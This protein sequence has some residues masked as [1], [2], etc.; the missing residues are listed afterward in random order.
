MWSGDDEPGSDTSPSYE[1]PAHIYNLFWTTV[2]TF[3]FPAHPFVKISVFLI[4]GYSNVI[5]SKVYVLE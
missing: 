5:Y 2:F 1:M 4:F 3:S